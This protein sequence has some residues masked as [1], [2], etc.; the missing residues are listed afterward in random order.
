MDF[1]IGLKGSGESSR[2]GS[3]RARTDESTFGQSTSVGKSSLEEF[4]DE[5]REAV[6]L[7]LQGK[8]TRI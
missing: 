4:T 8:M 6:N 3:A 5:P 2:A 7:A 1:G